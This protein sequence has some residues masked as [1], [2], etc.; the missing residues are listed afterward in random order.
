MSFSNQQ[1]SSISIISA[2]DI[3][4]GSA[5][6][7][8]AL[9]EGDT[10]F[11]RVLSQQ[12]K[13]R[14]AVSFAGQRF[15]VFSQRALPNGASFSAAVKIKD[16]S[17][18]LVLQNRTHTISNGANAVK[19][20]SFMEA[21]VSGRLNAFF[22]QAL[23]PS[24]DISLRL[25]QFFQENGL[26]FNGRQAQ[27]ARAAALRFAGR[28][29]EAAEAALFLLEKGVQ[30]DEQTLGELLDVLYGSS[31]QD[32]NTGDSAQEQDGQD[33]DGGS[34]DGK[35]SGHRRAPDGS[36][37]D[38]DGS[39]GNGGSLPVGEEVTG[40][41]APAVG[42]DTAKNAPDNLLQKLSLLYENTDECL[43]LPCGLLSFVNHYKTS[44]K[45]WIL[46][47]FD[48]DIGNKSFNGVIRLLL[49]TQEKKLEKIGI[50]AFSPVKNYFFMVHL[51]RLHNLKINNLKKLQLSVNYCVTPEPPHAQRR[52]LDAFLK[53]GVFG[54]A[55]I[56]DC[57][58][59]F[60][61]DL[62]RT[63]SFTEM[64]GVFVA[65]AEV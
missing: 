65:E 51:H 22:E 37:D 64:N 39:A 43:A 59:D 27:K 3:R 33:R 28:E 57:K 26:R 47:P 4:T 9:H 1:F 38:V 11:V 16:G 24:D 36:E 2:A 42:T 19:H 35:H 52:K 20:V 21:D 6:E 40:N 44:C 7:A 62:Y 25:L 31:E 58:I 30:P 41:W 15:N 63:G 46:L 29:K 17:I 53:E 56:A 54:N 13:N 61:P 32:G 5:A 48:Y 60:V 50:S 45:H 18:L 10:V 34:S 49:N 8:P 55:G 14:Y 23:L 12:G